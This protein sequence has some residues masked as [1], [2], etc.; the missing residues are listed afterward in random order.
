[1]TSPDWIKKNSSKLIDIRRWLH[2]N[3]EI[4]F[5]EHKTSEYLKN[6]LIKAGY[7]IIQKDKMK[8]GFFCEYSSGSEGP[9]LAIRCDMDGLLVSEESNKDYKS[10]NMSKNKHL[11]KKY[12]YHPC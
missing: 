12:I 9:T 10:I 6:Q 8:T 3:P 4:G 2:M 1:M 11:V 5:N 7:S